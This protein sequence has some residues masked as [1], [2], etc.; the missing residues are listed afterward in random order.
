M[1]N[2][3]IDTNEVQRILFL[4]ENYKNTLLKE[5]IKEPSKEKTRQELLKFFADA[6][7]E[8]CLT[9]PNLNYNSVFRTKKDD[10]TFRYFIKGPSSSMQGKIKRVY[11]DN[12]F[13]IIEPTTGNALRSSRWECKTTPLVPPKV[14]E[15][16]NSNQKKVLE[17]IGR[18]GWFSEPAPTEVE[19]ELGK[20]K[21]YNLGGTDKDSENT[22]KDSENTTDSNV[23]PKAEKHDLEQY[24]KWFKDLRRDFFV[25]KK[26]TK[27]PNEIVRKTAEK[28]SGQS[29]KR[30]IENLWNNLKNPNNPG[31][32]LTPQEISNFVQMA[33]ICKEPANNRKFILRFGLKD[34]LE[35]LTKS[36]FRI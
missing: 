11:D 14:T 10:G 12:T 32:Q 15:P 21:K 9:D 34:K 26:T 6:K 24:T 13:E 7:R 20:F 35:D 2:I 29:C 30:A 25:Y 27:L 18:D 36:K 33:K 22:T 16:L 28:V 8:G 31:F 23:N 3:K 19:V 5:E 17:I 4:H 1:K